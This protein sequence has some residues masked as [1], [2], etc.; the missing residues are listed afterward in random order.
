MNRK[1]PTQYIQK[2]TF[3]NFICI[4]V[5]NMYFLANLSSSTGTF[6]YLHCAPHLFWR[7][8]FFPRSHADNTDMES[9]WGT[10]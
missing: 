2:Y 10:A 8:E 4:F 6:S 5:K 1:L 3:A 9:P 7:S